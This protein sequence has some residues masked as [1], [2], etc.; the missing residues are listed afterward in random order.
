PEQL[1]AAEIVSFAVRAIRE[2]GDD[3]RIARLRL[4]LVDDLQE[5]TESTM[6]VLR[7]LLDRGVSV[8]AFGDPDVAANAFRGGEADVVGRFAAALGIADGDRLVL[9]TVH[10]G[11]P[12]LRAL[13]ARTVERIGTAAAGPQRR[14][15]VAGSADAAG[16]GDGADAGDGSDFG[17]GAAAG[18]DAP[19]P[20]RPP[21]ATLRATTPARHAAAIARVLREEHLLHGVPWSQ[22]AVVVRSGAQIPE[23]ARALSRAEVPTRT[24]GRGTPLRDDPAPRA[25][26]T[27]VEV[28]IGRRA[29]DAE[30][31]AELL[32][33]Q[34]GGLD[35]LG[36]RRLRLALRH[37]ELAGGG[38]RPGAELV[39]EALA[40]PGRLATI[41]GRAAK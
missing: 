19:H 2:G 35:P 16:S 39:A 21:V 31:A 38:T 13:V 23:L 8:V 11:G 29:L 33:G 7:A 37:E 17:E 6:N 4:V 3:D 20:E 1:D 18:T 28:G 40:A 14:A 10:R 30:T 26:L 22:L 15:T 34:F 12:E 25:L 41:E 24:T 36:L 27:V 9:E 32:T 5:A